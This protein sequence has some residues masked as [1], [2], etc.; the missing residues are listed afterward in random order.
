MQIS[1]PIQSKILGPSQE[2]VYLAYRL[3]GT[4]NIDIPKLLMVDMLLNNSKVGLIDVNL[5][6]NQNIQYG[7]C[8]PLLMH[9][10]SVHF[11]YGLPLADQSSIDV[12]NLILRQ[13]QKLEDGDFDEQKMKWI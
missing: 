12:K 13:I 9:E 11:F 1:K 6:Q 4:R 8:Y 2:V 3:D 5:N 7:G 10:Y